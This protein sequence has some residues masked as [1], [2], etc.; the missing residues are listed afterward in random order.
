M[1]NF[2]LKKYLAEGRLLKNNINPIFE[3][4]F[5][6]VSDFVKGKSD[7]EAAA[8][9][10]FKKG[11]IEVGKPFYNLTYGGGTGKDGDNAYW[12]MDHATPE[13]L[14]TL[15]VPVAEGFD[16]SAMKRGDALNK[17]ILQEIKE[18]EEGEVVIEMLVAQYNWKT[19][20]FIDE[21]GPESHNVIDADAIEKD[22][23]PK[24]GE[25]EFYFAI[26]MVPYI[27]SIWET[28]INKR[29]K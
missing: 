7:K 28:K 8:I 24:D 5:D 29:K 13:E 14:K 12:M 16:Q 22:L 19:G 11:G 3:S 26:E 1:D 2:N 9:E 18:N 21:D 10:A 23:N 20:K 27:G 15:K 4:I 17:N 25:S 6:K